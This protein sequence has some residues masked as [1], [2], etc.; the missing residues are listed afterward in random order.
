MGIIAWIVL[1]INVGAIAEHLVSRRESHGV[2]ITCLIG[3]ARDLVGGRAA[4]VCCG[5]P[6]PATRDP[7]PAT[8]D[9]R[10]GHPRTSADTAQG[11]P[12]AVG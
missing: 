3:I 9:P 6:R 11:V 4:A 1:G 8:R 2:I 12:G 10:P 5:D 7:R